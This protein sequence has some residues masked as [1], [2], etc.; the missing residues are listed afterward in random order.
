MKTLFSRKALHIG[1]QY[2][3]SCSTADAPKCI[4]NICIL[5]CRRAPRLR[6]AAAAMAP[7]ARSASGRTPLPSP[8]NLEVSVVDPNTLNLDPDPGLWPNLDL[9]PGP[10]PDPGLYFKFLK[11]NLKIILEKKFPLKLPPKEISTQLSP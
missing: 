4:N 6:R 2:F 8:G 9:D 7:P 3:I 5:Y 1:T 11:K 10:D